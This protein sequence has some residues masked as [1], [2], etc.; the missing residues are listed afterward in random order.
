MKDLSLLFVFLVKLELSCPFFLVSCFFGVC[1]DV[2]SNSEY[3][4]SLILSRFD[5][6]HPNFVIKMTTLQFKI[7]KYIGNYRM[8]IDW[9][10]WTE[11]FWLDWISN[12]YLTFAG[13]PESLKQ[14]RN[15]ESKYHHRFSISGSDKRSIRQTVLILT[16]TFWYLIFRPSQSH[17]KKVSLANNFPWISSRFALSSVSEISN[18]RNDGN[19]QEFL[20]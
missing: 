19:F 17:E 1:N 10:N 20:I 11:I 15:T 12:C 7:M 4:A 16:L 8:R 14:K 3:V 13:I 18:L 6:Q 5:P 2:T 9:K